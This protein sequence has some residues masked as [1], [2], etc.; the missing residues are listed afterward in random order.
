MRE[1]VVQAVGTEQPASLLGFVRNVVVDPPDDYPWPSP[2]AY[3]TVWHCTWPVDG[4]PSGTWL[5]AREA[6]AELGKRHWWPLAAHVPG[7]WE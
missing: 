3:F 5:D 7:W 6:S 2:E 1:L 4:E